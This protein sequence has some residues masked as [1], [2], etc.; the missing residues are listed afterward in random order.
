MA[1]ALATFGA[2]LLAGP[3]A[4][5]K[6]SDA[7]VSL[8]PGAQGVAGRIDVA[9][10]DLDA[11]LAL[12]ADRDGRITWSELRAREAELHSLLGAS[13]AFWSGERTCR[14]S[15]EALRVA[16]HSDGA[17]AVVPFSAACDASAGALRFAYGLFAGIDPSHRGLVR[18]HAGDD[19]LAWAFAPRRID[20]TATTAPAWAREIGAGSR[21]AVAA[22][23]EMTWQGMWHIWIGFD[24][25]LFLLALLFPAV[26]RREASAW[27]AAPSL[28]PA[29]VDVLKIV[30]AFTIAHT[31][32]LAL[33]AF[34]VLRLPSR[35][36]EAAIALSVVLA[37]VN[38]LVP[39]VHRSRWSVAFFLG[40]LHGLGFF[41]A[42]SDLGLEG[43]AIV[44]T[45]LGFN[46]GVELGQL[47]IVAAFVPVAF[48]A[49]SSWI[50]RRVALAGGSAAIAAVA[51][52]WTV[53]RIFD[54]S[55]WSLT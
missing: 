49:R 17:Y 7:Y 47:C 33:A 21:S 52:L 36:V 24:H 4:A 22:F 48:L 14:L 15:F 50:Y 38:N 27:R 9:L 51:T 32:T 28:R 1:S 44:S 19:T 35:V 12:D 55:I 30:T 54:A 6:P 31:L 23:V 34:D 26:M 3:A 20:F 37:A 11:V 8:R 10:R 39:V 25:I 29:L 42:L 16:R 13:L 46:L 45:L 43:G 53:E 40:L 18:V 2:V 5:H 41:G